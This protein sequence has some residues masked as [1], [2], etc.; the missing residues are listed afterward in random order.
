M[1]HVRSSWSYRSIVTYLSIVGQVPWTGTR[2][3]LPL[4]L[5]RAPI[6]RGQNCLKQILMSWL[7]PGL[8]QMLPILLLLSAT[9]TCILIFFLVKYTIVK[10]F[11]TF[12]PTC[13]HSYTP[14]P[15][16]ILWGLSSHAAFLPTGL[17]VWR[18][19]G[20]GGTSG[21]AVSLAPPSG[22]HQSRPLGAS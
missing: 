15:P 2:C 3:G 11:G 8:E 20:F 9:G 21:R 4:P 12:A 13:I 5:L 17:A 14:S 22:T 6:K 7:R 18:R 10:L 1:I 16:N 19:I